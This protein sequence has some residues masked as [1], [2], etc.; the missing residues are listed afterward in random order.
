MNVVNAAPAVGIR[1]ALFHLK[2]S[3]DVKAACELR[4]AGS[5]GHLGW[6]RGCVGGLV[7]VG[8]TRPQLVVTRP[9]IRRRRVVMC[10]SFFS[11]AH[12]LCVFSFFSSVSYFLLPSLLL[13]LLQVAVVAAVTF[14][15]VVVVV[16]VV[17]LAVVVVV[18]LVVVVIGGLVIK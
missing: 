3:D 16:V 6:C 4:Q 2:S 5:E 17:V 7:V 15:V 14:D 13:L 8:L 9:C 12:R 18:V 1:R 11:F 10:L